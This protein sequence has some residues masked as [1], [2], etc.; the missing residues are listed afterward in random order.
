MRCATPRLFASR[1]TWRASAAASFR[2]PWSTVTARSFGPRLCA[3]RQRA[4]RKSSAVESGPPETASTAAGAETRSSNRSLASAAE[5][6]RSSSARSAAD[7]LLFRCHV[8]FHV[9]GSAGVFAADFTPGRAGG[10]LFAQG[11]ERLPK[12]QQRLRRLRAA[13]EF[14]GHAEERLRRIAIAL[15]LIKA[16]AQPVLRVGDTAVAGIFFQEGAQTVFRQRVIFALHVTVSEIEFIARCRSR[17]R[18]A[19]QLRTAGGIGIARW[20]RR[21]QAILSRQCRPG[22]GSGEIERRASHAAAGSADRRR[23]GIRNRARHRRAERA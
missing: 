4:A 9:C 8:L 21:Q 12:P 10:F 7:T 14:G 20:R 1:A 17:R 18:D 15:A 6:G 11:G 23:C 22:S 16:F 3:L 2:K 19:R 5:S 13:V